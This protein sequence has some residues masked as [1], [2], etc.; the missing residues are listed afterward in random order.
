VD[1]LHEYEKTAE[2]ASTLDDVRTKLA[3]IDQAGLGV[4][5]KSYHA[6]AALLESLPAKVELARLFQVDMLKPAPEASLGPMVLDEISRGVD[7]LHRLPK[8][9]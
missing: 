5:A 6:V 2:Y 9:R 3:E 8:A 7:V 4:D 1:Q